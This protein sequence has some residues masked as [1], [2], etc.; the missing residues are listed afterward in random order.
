MSKINEPLMTFK[1]SMIYHMSTFFI[2]NFI[3]DAYFKVSF[4]CV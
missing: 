1:L 3:K 4:Y 2:R